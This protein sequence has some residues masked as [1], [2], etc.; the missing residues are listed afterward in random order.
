MPGIRTHRFTG[1]TAP[2]S[3]EVEAGH[4]LALDFRQVKKFRNFEVSI[5]SSGGTIWNEINYSHREGRLSRCSYR[6]LLP[7]GLSEISSFDFRIVQ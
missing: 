5:P 2:P 7:T 6:S 1:L 3:P 4:Y